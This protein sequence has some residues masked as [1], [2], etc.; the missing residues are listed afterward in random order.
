MTIARTL[1][2]PAD[3]S[4]GCLRAVF[5]RRY[6]NPILNTAPIISSGDGGIDGIGM[7]Q[8][9]ALVSFK[10]LCHAETLVRHLFHD[11][12]SAPHEGRRT[13]NMPSG[14]ALE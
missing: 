10:V 8:V 3:E 11:A 7:L 13:P 9:N 1:A 6:A 2:Q 5:P 4:L 14:F 12:I